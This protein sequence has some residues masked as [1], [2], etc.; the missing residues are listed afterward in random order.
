[1]IYLMRHGQIL[2]HVEKR[3]M[4]KNL[5][6]DLTTLG[7]NQA[8]NAGLWLA[9]KN[10]SSIFCS[11]FQHAEKTA[12]IISRVLNLTPEIK[13]DLREIDCGDLDERTDRDALEL[14][15]LTFEHWFRG[16]WSVSFPGGESFSDVYARFLR[17][18]HQF[19]SRQNVLLITHGNVMRSV[20][21]FICVNAA[22]LQRVEIPHST[23]FI[24]LEP[25]DATRYI[26]ESWNLLEHLA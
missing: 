26:C 10:I 23:G 8:H 5:D 21:P 20:V 12:Y 13:H 14:W 4:C 22:A 24:L 25:Y 1:M 18:L 17:I 7:Y 2:A 16:D 6:A 9:N 11:P 19:D 3:I 15:S